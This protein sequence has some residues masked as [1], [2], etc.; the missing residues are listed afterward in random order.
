M[1]S[2]VSKIAYAVSNYT[3]HRLRA[4]VNFSAR[5]KSIQSMKTYP[6]IIYMVPDHKKTADEI[7]QGTS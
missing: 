3:S 2:A 6:S 7:S 1:M 4:N 5:E